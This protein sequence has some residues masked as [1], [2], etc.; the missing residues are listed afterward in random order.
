MSDFDAISIDQL[1]AVGG[2][3]WARFPDTIGAFIAEMDFGIAEPITAALHEAVE[4]GSFGYLTPGPVRAMGEAYAAFADRSFGWQID[5]GDVRA[6]PDVL[7]GLGAAIRFLSEPGSPIIIP[8]PAYMPFLDIPRVHERQIL[9]VPMA[10]DGTRH[11][12]D[13]DALDAA[14]AAGGHLM[15]LCNPHNPIGRV[16]EPDEMLAV[17][18]VVERHGGRVFADEIH[19]PLVYPGHRHVP[20]ASLTEVTAGHTITATSTSKAWNLPGLKAAQL[21][22]SND[23]DRKV[24]RSAGSIAADGTANLGVVAAIAAYSEGGPWLARVLEYLDGNRALLGDLLA[25]HLPG[26]HYRAPEGTYLGWIDCRDLGLNIPPGQFFRKEAGV[27]L[28]EGGLCG[29]VGRG[30]IRYNFATPRPILA[31]GV[32]ALGAAVHAASGTGTR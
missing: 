26:A 31:E 2:A 21:V 25:E 9:Q 23:H 14:F 8:T 19:A 20:Y 29:Q 13:L 27:M 24:W 18:D 5:P 3:K 7:T 1:R 17:A 16:L 28:T 10:H 30:F 6:I 11:H 15:V 12:Y 32:R 4:V 22:L